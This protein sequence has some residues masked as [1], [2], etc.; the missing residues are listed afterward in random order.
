MAKESLTAKQVEHIKPGAMRSEFPAGPPSGL[1]LALHP[2]GKK[3][4][5]FRY[6]WRG[7]PTK[8][9]F[10]KAYP[11]MTLAAARAEAQAAVDA[12]AKGENPAAISAEEK[13]AEPNAAVQVAEEWL[14]RD[15]RP[16]VRTWYEIERVMRKMMEEAKA[17]SRRPYEVAY[18][19]IMTG[20]RALAL[21]WLEKAYQHHDYWMLFINVDPGYD[22][23]RSDPRFQSIIHR[24]GVG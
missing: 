4:W 20:D 1:Y 5:A 8:I 19:A 11:D 10:A 15:V 23:I 2:T 24:L 14:A 3:S 12:L 21:D 7:I 13:K 6:R 9:T 16:R 18:F 17:G 22:S